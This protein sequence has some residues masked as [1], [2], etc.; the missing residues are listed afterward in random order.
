MQIIRRF[1]RAELEELAHEQYV[2]EFPSSPEPRLR[3]ANVRPV[4]GLSGADH[5]FSRG[6]IWEVPAI[7]FEAGAR[8]VEIRQ[9]LES[10]TAA[11]ET[12]ETVQLYLELL[13][14]AVALFPRLVRPQARGLRRLL[15]RMGIRR[16]PWRDA[17]EEEVGEMVGFFY[18][19]RTRSPGRGRAGE[20]EPQARP[21]STSSTGSMSSAPRSAATRPAGGT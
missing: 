8:L 17:S 15:W 20:G 16:N 19:S 21:H 14:S 1:S 5:V 7:P 10:L 9:G 2:R 18:R 13:R 4:L 6:K 11:Q 12:P 3:F